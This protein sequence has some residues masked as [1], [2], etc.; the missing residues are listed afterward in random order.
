MKKKIIAVAV[1]LSIAIIASIGINFNISRSTTTLAMKNI[2]AL[3]RGEGDG[4]RYHICYSESRVKI[5]YSYYDCGDC[6]TKVTDEQGKG[7]Y[8]KC[9][10]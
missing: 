9:F 8:T 7:R 2:E 5:G 10:Y 1:F 4:T 6:P 3:A